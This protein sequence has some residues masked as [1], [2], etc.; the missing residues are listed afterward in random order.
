[1]NE[2][3]KIILNET[4]ASAVQNH[5]KGNFQVAEK[6]YK[7][8]LNVDPK[9]LQSIILLGTLSGQTK[10]F[11]LA[12]QL[13]QKAIKINPNYAETHYKLGIILKE[14]GEVQEAINS[15]EKAI[16]INPNYVIAYNNLGLAF[17]ELNE[18]KK[19]ASCYEKALYLDPSREEIC[20][21]Y[22]N[23]LLILNMHIKALTY[24]KKGTGF[25]CFTQK[26]VKII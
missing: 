24:I 10:N 15:Y 23:L 17:R 16:E 20:E 11:N 26:D 18:L 6:L 9:H 22:G 8:I 21:G 3:K 7:E 2:K 19:A 13:L 4:F 5:K 25:I 14:L 1:M 12:K